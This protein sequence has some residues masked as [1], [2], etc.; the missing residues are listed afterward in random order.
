MKRT[1]FPKRSIE[2]V[3]LSL[4]I[5]LWVTLLAGCGGKE[6]PEISQK[7]MKT[8]KSYEEFQKVVNGAGSKLLVF[9]LYADWCMPCKMLSPLLEQLAVEHKDKAAI[10]KI[11][12]D[13]NPQIARAFGVR[14]IPYVVFMKNK[15]AVHAMTGVQ[16]KKAYHEAIVQ[17]H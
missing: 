1:F 7:G 12:V 14:G 6:E 13:T 3:F 5:A 4:G 2:T 9:D 8:I 15:Q 11:N 10:Y 17:L 16:P